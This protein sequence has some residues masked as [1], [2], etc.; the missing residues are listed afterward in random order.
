[1]AVPGAMRR[2][3]ALGTHHIRR[4]FSS[5]ARPSRV[6]IAFDIDGVLVRGRDPL[7]GAREALRLVREFSAPHVF[8]T[9]GGGCPESTKAEQ[10]SEWLG[11]KVAPEQVILSHSPFRSLVARHADGLVLVAGSGQVLDVAKTYGFKDAVHVSDVVRATP[12]AWPFAEKKLLVAQ[13]A[14]NPS[15]M[16]LSRVEAVML[17]HDPHDWGESIQVMC[18]AVIARTRA[19]GEPPAV[20]FSN[21]DFVFAGKHPEPRLAQGAFHSA[22][23]AVYRGLTGLDL[24]YKVFGKPTDA[25][26]AYAERALELQTNGQKLDT[27]FG[28]GDNPAADVAG[29]NARPGWRSVLLRTGVWDGK[30]KPSDEPD[31]V[32]DGVLDAVSSILDSDF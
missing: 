21:P 17:F 16:D 28:I 14:D 5:V 22:L 10:L 26:Y 24:E 19:A 30:S 31:H 29:A 18:D 32:C 3:W 27:V 6:G 11:V 7:P 15:S 25:T 4:L 23:C 9:N 20:Y 12:S 2:P 8:L 1:M 13:G